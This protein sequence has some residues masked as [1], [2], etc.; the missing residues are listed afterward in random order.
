MGCFSAK[1]WTT[2]FQ[3]SIRKQTMENCC[4]F[5][6]LS[7]E[8]TSMVHWSKLN[9]VANFHIIIM[10]QKCHDYVTPVI[11]LLTRYNVSRRL[12]FFMANEKMYWKT[13]LIRPYYWTHLFGIRGWDPV[14][15]HPLAPSS[16]CYFYWELPHV[17]KYC[18]LQKNTILH[19]ATT[20]EC[21][22]C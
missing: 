11:F 20:I 17:L 5:L 14:Q 13:V 22:H 8:Q 4:R 12:F 16:R 7:R 15:L 3:W 21:S 1:F 10:L 2:S 6:D 18:K 9:N 19:Q